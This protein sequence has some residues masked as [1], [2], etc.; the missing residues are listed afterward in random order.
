[1][2]I[3]QGSTWLPL[4]ISPLK[5]TIFQ[6]QA[7]G[8]YH[9]WIRWIW[10]RDL[11]LWF[12]VFK[13]DF[14]LFFWRFSIVIHL[15]YANIKSLQILRS[16]LLCHLFS[17]HIFATYAISYSFCFNPEVRKVSWFLTW[18]TILIVVLMTISAK[19][20]YTSTDLIYL[21]FL[22]VKKQTLKLHHSTQEPK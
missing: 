21:L 10:R 6:L 8:Y 2:G 14:H 13:I 5:L 11:G 4:D 3:F 7:C 17:S 1:M 20:D 12:Q 19:I 15:N 9:L 16:I 22:E 18:G